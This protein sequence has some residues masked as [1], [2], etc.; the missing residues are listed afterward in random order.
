[1]TPVVISVVL[2]VGYNTYAFNDPTGPYSSGALVANSVSAM[3]FVGLLIDQNQGLIVQQP[4]HMLGIGALGL[5]LRRDR[6]GFATIVLVLQLVWPC[7]PAGAGGGGRGRRVCRNRGPVAAGFG[8][9]V[10]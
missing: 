6:L 8:I 10:G 9:D 3:V 5:L 1:L 2:L 4:L 7:T